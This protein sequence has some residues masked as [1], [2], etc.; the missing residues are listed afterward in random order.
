MFDNA[1]VHVMIAL[2][3]LIATDCF[4][5]RAVER[6]RALADRIE[7]KL[8]G[9]VEDENKLVVKTRSSRRRRRERGATTQKK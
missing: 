9:A 8:E 6:L 3:R 4:D 1:D 7:Q 5:L 2:M